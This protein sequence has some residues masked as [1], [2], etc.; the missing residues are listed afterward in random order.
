MERFRVA[1]ALAKV[2]NKHIGSNQNRGTNISVTGK[3]EIFIPE[4]NM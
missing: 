4:C 2:I 1:P 3:H